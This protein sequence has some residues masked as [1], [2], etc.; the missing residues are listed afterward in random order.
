M[1][2]GKLPIMGGMDYFIF[3][4]TDKVN[5]KRNRRRKEEEE[6]DKHFKEMSN[7]SHFSVIYFTPES[8]KQELVKGGVSSHATL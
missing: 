6:K 8:R 2:N 3:A 5:A 7:K 1:S 4:V